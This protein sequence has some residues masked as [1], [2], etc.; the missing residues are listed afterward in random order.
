MDS[1]GR[2]LLEHTEA[3]RRLASTRLVG[4]LSTVELTSFNVD[5]LKVRYHEGVSEMGGLLQVVGQVFYRGFQPWAGPIQGLVRC[6][7]LVNGSTRMKR[8]GGATG[9]ELE[10]L[11]GS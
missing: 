8:V 11:G 3:R 7:R 5:R 2:H 4:L 6:K 1:S 10:T 9:L